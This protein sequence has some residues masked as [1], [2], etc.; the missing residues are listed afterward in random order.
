M[1]AVRAD[2][3]VLDN[4]VWHAMSGAQ[5]E[6]ADHLGR[7]GRFQR[8]VAPFSGMDDP[9]ST[10]AWDDLARLVGPGKPAIL[11]LPGVVVPDG[12]ETQVAMPCFQMVATNVSGAAMSDEIV[13]LGPQDVR[14][15]LALVDATR[16]GPFSERTIALGRYVGIRRGGHLVAM[17]GERV[18]CPGYTE[19]SA[20]CTA[21][22]VRGQ[23]LAR[24]LVL[25]VV[26]AIRARGDEAFLH[27]ETGNTPAIGLYESMGFTTRI[28]AEASIIRN[29][30][31][32][33][34]PA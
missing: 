21:D 25:D 24:Q 28:E 9:T 1:P 31:P 4:V 3:A 15:M 16:P 5:R 29:T 18:K 34:G 22:E 8:D 23:G 7:A 6:L 11:F 27:V 17:T 32:D 2:I 10:E 13:E 26:A 19:V 14:D 30:R 33:P 20:V 12:W